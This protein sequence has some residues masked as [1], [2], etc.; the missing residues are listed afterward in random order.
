[1]KA[2]EKSILLADPAPDIGVIKMSRENF[3][4]EWSGVA[5]L[6]TPNDEY[7]PVKE[8][9]RGLLALFRNLKKQWKL[10]MKIVL[11]AMLVTLIS[12]L[13]SYFLQ[14]LID[15][16]IPK[17]ANDILPI[18]ASGLLVAYIFNSMFVYIRDSL[19]IILG[20]RLSVEIILGYIRH[21]F[22]LPMNFL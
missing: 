2:D 18:I 7:D 10:L 8:N 20:Q 21:I 12:I 3:E 15:E 6:F 1:M 13:G 16:Y 5:L 11:V 22:E 9:Q 19:L 14:V 17:K 4:K